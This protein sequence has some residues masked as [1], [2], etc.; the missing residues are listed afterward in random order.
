LTTEDQQQVQALRHGDEKAFDNIFR[1]WY[2]PLVRY[3]YSFTE[4]NLDE[5]E[6]LVQDSFAKLWTQRETLDFQHSLKA[7]LYK[8]VH[9][10]ALNRLRSQRTHERYTTHQTRHMANEF[11]APQ[12]NPELQ[13]R[14]QDVINALPTQ[15]RQVF[16][17]SRFEELKY[18]EIAEQ[19]GI[20]VKTVETHM[21][22]A[23]RI[24]RVEL[25]EY[26]TLILLFIRLN[27]L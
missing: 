12:D 11:E 7:Y 2:T 5:A 20:S 24:L 16:G 27:N 25:A 3:A 10:Q 13:K 26:L 17:L 4:G 19:L 22:K 6:D 23:L 9:N 18:R 15:C 21:G 14:I 1:A 8:M